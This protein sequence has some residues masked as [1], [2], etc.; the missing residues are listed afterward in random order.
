MTNS[1]DSMSTLLI[2][3]ATNNTTT[4]KGLKNPRVAKA[5]VESGSKYRPAEVLRC[6]DNVYQLF[7]SYTLFV[8]TRSLSYECLHV[9]AGNKRVVSTVVDISDVHSSRQHA[10]LQT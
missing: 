3:T 2:S 10:D 7:Y 6:H 4:T 8:E 9:S 1:S 5:N